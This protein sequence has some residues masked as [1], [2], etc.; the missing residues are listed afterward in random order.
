MTSPV[1]APMQWKRAHLLWASL[2]MQCLLV[3]IW[4]FSYSNTFATYVYQFIVGF[5][6]AQASTATLLYSPGSI[7]RRCTYRASEDASVV[8]ILAPFSTFVARISTKNKPAKHSIFV[9]LRPIRLF[10]CSENQPMCWDE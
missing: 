5:K 1:F 2:V 9:R 7:R 4:E 3:G 8:H 10:A 6:I